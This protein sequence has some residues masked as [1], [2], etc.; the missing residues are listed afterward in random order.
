MKHHGLLL[1]NKP[2]PSS[3]GRTSSQRMPG[4]SM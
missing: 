3:T 2:V 4:I 1:K